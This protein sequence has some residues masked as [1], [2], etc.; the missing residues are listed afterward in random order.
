MYTNF[1]AVFHLFYWPNND[2]DFHKKIIIISKLFGGLYYINL[3]I[4]YIYLYFNIAKPMWC[5]LYNIFVPTT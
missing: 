3:Y 2:R 5:L 4:M 1:I